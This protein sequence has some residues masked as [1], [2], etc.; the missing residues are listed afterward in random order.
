[1]D[2]EIRDYIQGH[3]P[4]TEGEAYGDISPEVTFR[5]IKQLPTYII[6]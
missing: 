3:T 2:P 1:M 6:D 5:E 4:R